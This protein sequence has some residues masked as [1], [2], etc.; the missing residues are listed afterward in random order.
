MLTCDVLDCHNAPDL[1][2]FSHAF[3]MTRA[4]ELLALQQRINPIQLAN[5]ASSLRSNIPSTI[6]ALVAAEANR[7]VLSKVMGGMNVHL[8][9]LFDDNVAWIARFQRTTDDKGDH[10]LVNEELD[11]MGIIDWEWSKV[12]TKSFAFAAPIMLLPLAFDEGD[13]QLTED[14]EELAKV[15]ESLGRPDMTLCVR[16]GRVYH[17]ISFI[18]HKGDRPDAC[19]PQMKGFYQLPG[20]ESWEWET[21][22][23]DALQMY[24]TE[25]VLQGLLG[26]S[27]STN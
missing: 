3:V 15:F 12:V 4:A 9:I 7:P 14:E 23:S 11:T 10:I 20:N 21:W 16:G 5:I 25:P 18:L 8:E 1:D 17:H 27:R 22:R 26:K 6:P 19:K 13:N 2:A 24:Q